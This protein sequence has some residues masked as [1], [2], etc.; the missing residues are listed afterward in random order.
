MNAISIGYH[1]VA[2]S[3]EPTGSGRP[4]AA[5][6]R[7][8]RASFQRHLASIYSKVA[9]GSVESID[10]YRKWETRV[11]IFLTFDDGEISAYQFVAAALEKWGWRGHFFITTDWIGCPGFLNPSQIRE[12]RDRGHVI[13]SHTCSHPARMS[14][15]QWPELIREWTESCAI[16]CDILGEAVSVASVADGYYSRKVGRSAAASGIQ[17]LFTSEPT[18]RTSKVDGCLVLGRYG[19]LRGMPTETSGALVSSNPWHCWKQAVWW[20]LKKPVKLIGGDSYLRIRRYVLAGGGKA[21]T[22]KG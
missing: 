16:L 20:N 15:L 10:S 7:L 4:T 21:G 1:D 2:D 22:T 5:V 9:R 17:V 18:K 13:G 12:L 11:P 14:S 19:V 6:Y 8:D 3:G